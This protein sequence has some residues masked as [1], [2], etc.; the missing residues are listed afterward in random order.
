MTNSANDIALID[1][2]AYGA[3]GVASTVRHGQS[4]SFDVANVIKLHRRWW[5]LDA[6]IDTRA[7]FGC[8]QD[9][10]DTR[11]P[12][13]SILLFP[14]FRTF[15]S[16]STLI[17]R[18]F[19]ASNIGIFVRHG[20]TLPGCSVRP[21]GGV[22]PKTAASLRRRLKLVKRVNIETSRRNP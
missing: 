17:F 19:G 15:R 6:A 10:T 7:I 8:E 12:F 2:G 16:V 4:K 18:L 9:G 3:N 14:F 5:V 11:S 22:G 20:L 21:Q 1:F 13:A